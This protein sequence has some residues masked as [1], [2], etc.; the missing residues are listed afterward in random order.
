[1]YAFTNILCTIAY[2]IGIIYYSNIIVKIILK[3][4]KVYYTLNLPIEL[5]NKKNAK[6]ILFSALLNVILMIFALY[7]Y[8]IKKEIL[9]SVFC[10]II[11]LLSLTIV[12]SRLKKFQS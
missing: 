5:N 4:D 10:V 12:S 6:I 3:S 1:M 8:W 11:F 9:M 7:F 2:V